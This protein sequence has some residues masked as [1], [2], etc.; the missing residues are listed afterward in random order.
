MPVLGLRASKSIGKGTTAMDPF[1]LTEPWRQLVAGALK[2]QGRYRALVAAAP[3]GAVREQLLAVGGRIDDA[4]AE[5]WAIAQQ[6]NRLDRTAADMRI[7]VTRSQ[8]ASVP[9]GDER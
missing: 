3:E 2:S 8:L 5:C 7:E 1:T 9:A 4:V 6:G